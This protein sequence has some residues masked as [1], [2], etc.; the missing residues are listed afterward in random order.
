MKNVIFNDFIPINKFIYTRFNVFIIIVYI[1]FLLIYFLF[2]YYFENID[3]DF[4]LL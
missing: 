1:V 3:F 2:Y 4:F